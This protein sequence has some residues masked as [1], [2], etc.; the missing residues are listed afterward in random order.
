MQRR[1][2]EVDALDDLC[3][4]IFRLL[5]YVRVRIREEIK[6]ICNA[7]HAYIQ[8]SKRANERTISSSSTAANESLMG[9][10]VTFGCTHIAG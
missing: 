5:L 4:S 2:G 7:M 6:R 1:I 9:V 3:L 10:V 8:Q